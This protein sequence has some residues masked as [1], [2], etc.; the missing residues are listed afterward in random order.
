MNILKFSQALQNPSEGTK[1]LAGVPLEIPGVDGRIILKW[2][3][4]K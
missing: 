4:K 1:V 3:T 2:I